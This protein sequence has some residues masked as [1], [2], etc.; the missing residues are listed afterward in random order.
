M[1]PAQAYPVGQG[2]FWENPQSTAGNMLSLLNSY[3]EGQKADATAK[4]DRAASL[5]GSLGPSAISSGRMDNEGLQAMLQAAGLGGDMSG[6]M[7]WLSPKVETPAERKARLEGDKLKFQSE[8]G[9]EPID[10]VKAVIGAE[11]GTIGH[12]LGSKDIL[13]VIT[14]LQESFQ[15]E[16]EEQRLR[17]MTKEQLLLAAQQEYK[18]LVA[19]GYTKDQANQQ[20]K[21]KYGTYLQGR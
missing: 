8:G 10:I 7:P 19:A 9:M 3:Y 15:K 2:Q 17:S 14:G 12:K 13:N 21:D 1:I 16:Q 5:V 11:A 20:L 6:G 4:T 18:Q